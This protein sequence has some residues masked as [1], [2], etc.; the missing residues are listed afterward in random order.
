MHLC[1]APGAFITAT[2]HFLTL[3]YPHL[4]FNYRA[5]TLNP[6]YEGNSLGNIILDDRFILHTLPNWFFGESYSGDILDEK[7]IR[8][9]IEQCKKSKEPHLVTGDGSI[10]CLDKPECQEEHVSK[11]HTAEFITALA[12]LADGGSLLLKYFTFYETST[13]SQLYV[14]NCC[15]ESVHV[16]KPGS[17]KEG[18]S[19]VYVIATGYQ[20]NLIS[21][22]LIDKLLSN[23]KSNNTMLQLQSI[24]EDFLEQVTKA[25]NFFMN[26]QVAVIEGNIKAYKN[27]DKSEMY[28]LKGL[29]MA[30]AQYYIEHYRIKPI[31]EHHKL[32]HGVQFM[33]DINM[34]IRVHSGSHSERISFHKLC[35]SDQ[36]Q[37]LYDRLKNIY[38]VVSSQ[39]MSKDIVKLY[40][41]EKPKYFLKLIYG[42]SIK[43]VMSSKF[44]LETVM[45]YFIELREFESFE[46]D[47]EDGQKYILF[48]K[49]NGLQVDPISFLMA[50]NYD[51]YEK[52]VV[53]A[54]LSEILK[55]SSEEF[56]IKD[57]LF[58]TQFL[59]GFLIYLGSFVFAEIQFNTEAGEI[60]LTSLKSD[61]M[62]NV[63]HLMESLN[64]KEIIGICDTKL[65]FNPKLY[66]SIVNYNNVLCLKYCSTLLNLIPQ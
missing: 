8:S 62:T 42:R 15:F 4:K 48:I 60:K 32:L 59:V 12:I 29:K 61:A 23:F 9:L 14:L 49:K 66:R 51:S 44:V 13:V 34:N 35:R 3:N 21:E 18:N 26:L 52:Y 40:V 24:P 17:S 47:V 2:N 31:H 43:S 10:D 58:I 65:L 20:K 39:P 7:N 41:D 11:L 37:V 56:I 19:E 45:K 36:L 57:L 55:N 25:A 46:E 33:S 6:Y 22:E 30:T 5:T 50:Q 1:E 27:Y 54:I 53:N 38:D 63:K 28:R 16:F 64:V